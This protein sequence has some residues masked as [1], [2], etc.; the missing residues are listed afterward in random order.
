MPFAFIPPCVRQVVHGLTISA[1]GR[2]LLSSA[3][4]QL[5]KGRRYGLLGSNGSGKSTLLRFL[6][7]KPCRLPIPPN[8]DLLLV[9]R[10][11]R[12][13]GPIHCGLPCPLSPPPA[14]L[15]RPLPTCPTPP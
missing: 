5:L 1:P 14:P 10:R 12:R 3:N 13:V 2:T 11:W 9:S 4:L 6:A 8:I 15:P 7:E